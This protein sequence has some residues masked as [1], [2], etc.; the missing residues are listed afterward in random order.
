MHHP[1]PERGAQRRDEGRP[2][3]YDTL[4]VGGGAAGCVLAARLSEDPSRR[5]LLIEAGPDHRG[6]REVLDA[7]HWDAMIGGPYDYG[8]RS[9]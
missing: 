3:A 4:I 2:A 6:V 5:V 7:A 9:T 1:V 8:Y